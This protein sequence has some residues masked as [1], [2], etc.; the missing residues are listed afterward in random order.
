MST[1]FAGKKGDIEISTM[2]FTYLF[3]A[4][5]KLARRLE[6]GE[7]VS[8]NNAETLAALSEELERRVVAR[9]SE[10]PDSDAQA[11]SDEEVRGL[12]DDD[13]PPEFGG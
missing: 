11:E 6:A 7:D 13:L 3:N 5:N 12:P 4:R 8:P 10:A 9:D 2:P 1:Y